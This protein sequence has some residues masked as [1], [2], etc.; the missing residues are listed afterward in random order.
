MEVLNL[1]WGVLEVIGWIPSQV[2]IMAF[3]PNTILQL[4]VV[5]SDSKDLI[6]FPFILPLNF[7][8]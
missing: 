2:C 5:Q 3:P 8:G 1:F 4:A 6:N 7:D